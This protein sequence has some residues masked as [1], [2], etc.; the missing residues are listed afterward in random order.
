VIHE[1]EAELITE[2][3]KPVKPVKSEDDW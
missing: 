3:V 1:K 2:P